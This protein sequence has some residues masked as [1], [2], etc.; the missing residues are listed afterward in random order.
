MNDRLT[1]WLRERVDEACAFR[2]QCDRPA[3]DLADS[4]LA[5]LRRDFKA[6]TP[7]DD[8]RAVSHIRRRTG[9]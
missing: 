5:E 4:L 1:R 8:E 6:L 9:T 3:Y 2:S 7:A